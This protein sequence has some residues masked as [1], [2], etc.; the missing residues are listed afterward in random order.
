MRTVFEMRTIE[1]IV[2]LKQPTAGPMCRQ[3]AFFWMTATL[4]RSFSRSSSHH[5][6]FDEVHCSQRPE[7][8]RNTSAS[9]I[10]GEKGVLYRDLTPPLSEMASQSALRCVS[11]SREYTL[12]RISRYDLTALSTYSILFVVAKTCKPKSLFSCYSKMPPW[13]LKQSVMPT[14]TCGDSRVQLRR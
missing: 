3:M 12:L 7:E 14:K 1:N 4:P 2:N 11:S 13:S 9:L 5:I 10:L 6:R 8:S